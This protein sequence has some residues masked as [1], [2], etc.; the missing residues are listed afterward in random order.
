MLQIVYIVSFGN[1]VK[2]Y[3]KVKGA[4]Q[5]K[6]RV[7]IQVSPTIPIM[8]ST[9]KQYNLGAAIVPSCHISLVSFNPEQFLSS[10]LT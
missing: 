8:P 5:K 9:A 1:N 10:S 6:F 3:R 2:K 7:L 4:A